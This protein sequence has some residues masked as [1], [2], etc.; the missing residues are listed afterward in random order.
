MKYT[1][2]IARTTTEP[3]ILREILLLN[4]DNLLSREAAC[5]PNCPSDA[6]EI[7]L[8]RNRN[9]FVSRYA[10]KN[11]NAPNKAVL[12]WMRA[13]GKIDKYDPSKHMTDYKPDKDLEQ[14]KELIK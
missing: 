13:V 10:S 9:D 3:N 5:N 2:K 8:K 14:L 6:L 12:D 11:P 1:E 7:V 4:Q